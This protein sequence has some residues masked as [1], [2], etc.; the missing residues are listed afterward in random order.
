MMV[1]QLSVVGT[2]WRPGV[3]AT[4]S[5]VQ[6]KGCYTQCSA[7]QRNYMHRGPSQVDSDSSHNTWN[8]VIRNLIQQ[9]KSSSET[10]G[11]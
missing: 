5:A 7:V 8:Q 1:P 6:C 4:E 9:S 10:P 3:M 11:M 2:S